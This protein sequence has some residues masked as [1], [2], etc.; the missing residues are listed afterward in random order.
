MLLLVNGLTICL[1]FDTKVDT[2]VFLNQTIKYKIVLFFQV[3]IHKIL[4]DYM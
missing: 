3:R 4:Y 1:S 2:L